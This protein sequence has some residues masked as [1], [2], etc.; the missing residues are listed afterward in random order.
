MKLHREL[1]L[2]DFHNA[3]SDSEFRATL[4]AH[5]LFNTQQ[6]VL[7]LSPVVHRAL[8]SV[9]AGIVSSSN[10]NF[11]QAQAMSTYLHETVHWWQHIGSTYGFLLS[12]NYPV[13]SHST[14][15]DLKRLVALNGFKKSVLKQ[16]LPLN[17][18]G[19]TGAGTAAGHANFVVNTH[20]DLLA[21]RALTLGQ[22]AK[23]LA[24]NELFDSVGHAFH[25]TY[26]NTLGILASTVDPAFSVIP[27]P[28][29]W[30]QGF[31]DLRQR[32]V[33]GFHR[34]SPVDLWPIGSTEIFEGQARF[35]QIQYLS[36]ASG[37]NLDWGEF[38]RLG[39]LNGVYVKAFEQF[40]HLTESQ[41]PSAVS[42][43]LVGLFL[44][45]CELA[46]NP[47]RGF[48][49]SVEP[50]YETFLL[51][52]NPGARFFIVCRLIAVQHAAVKSAITKHDRTEYEEVTTLLSAAAK[53]HPPLIL[54]Q[55]FSDWFS[56]TGKLSGLYS[57]FKAYKFQPLNYVIRHLFAH[58]LAFQK[59]KVGAPEF[60][61]WPG[62]WMAGANVSGRE[63]KLFES[64]SA[65]FVDREDDDGVFPRTQAERTDAEVDRA[66]QDFYRNTVVY[67][68]VN[69][70]IAEDGPFKYHMEWL[71]SGSSSVQQKHFLQDSFKDRKS[72]V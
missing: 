55:T 11:E 30:G 72:V 37:H 64:H 66:F 38:R 25:M 21:F 44:L 4:N 57:E 7:R 32:K 42:D 58:F 19:P 67:G 61:C 68:L 35:C 6:F 69:Q 31:D 60:F 62:A 70:W 59:D 12:L 40:L 41:W 27:D 54:S 45:V 8:A 2:A 17:E 52:A 13:Q 16:S 24:Q 48:P 10:M 28:R 34:D 1:V 71:K 63:M 22:G 3:P 36:Y 33:D 47:G 46:I 39:M 56:E 49:Y 26:A 53:E 23:S 43:S 29:R 20:F 14:H 15:R 18:Q 5:G 51:D 50:N 65:P 9:P